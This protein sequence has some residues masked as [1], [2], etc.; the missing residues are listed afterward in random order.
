ML[1]VKE[2]F[3]GKYGLWMKEEGEREEGGN[4]EDDWGVTMGPESYEEGQNSKKKGGGGGG[5]GHGRDG[6][7]KRTGWQGEAEWQETRVMTRCNLAKAGTWTHK[8]WPG[9]PGGCD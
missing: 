9:N 5:G 3:A 1:A 8:W 7:R 2:K 6:T 4:R